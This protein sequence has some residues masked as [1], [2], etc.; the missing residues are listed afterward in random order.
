MQ[1]AFLSHKKNL[2]FDRITNI[3]TMKNYFILFIPFIVHTAVLAQSNMA[4]SFMVNDIKVI[5]KPTNKDI[6]HVS[7]YFRGGVGNYPAEKAGIEKLAVIGA[8]DCGNK[9]YSTNEFKDKSDLFGIELSASSHLDDSRISLNCISKY[10]DEGWDLF[11]QSILNPA[12]NEEA[13]EKVKQNSY[14]SMNQLQGNPDTRLKSL[15]VQNAFSGTPYATSPDGTDSS[16][17]GLSRN[18]VND[19]Y[20]KTLLNKTRIFIV[21]VGKISKEEIAARIAASFAGIPAFE[22]KISSFETPGFTKTTLDIE[23]RSIATNYILGIVN[24]P[25]YTS[26]DYTPYLLSF[27]ELSG[28][29]FAELRMNTGLSYA[30]GAHVYPLL[31]PYADVHVSTTSP[32]EAVTAIVK[33][34][35]TEENS[36]IA[37]KSLAQI[38]ALYITRNYMKDE[39]TDAI[40]ESLGNSEILGNW[41]IAE[42]FPS[43]LKNTTRSEMSAVFKKYITGIKWTYLGDKAKAD[44]SMSSFYNDFK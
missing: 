18:E 2:Q 3:Y 8:I 14:A 37:R 25:S 31:M 20:Y 16:L 43:L 30:P 19:Y 11:S 10:F 34:I 7:L 38:K 41:M 12:Y 42:Q 6:I 21:V 40:A 24:A 36:S 13:F 32:K 33:A 5:Y 35:Q 17:A 15:A 9:K 27:S 23:Q 22:Y 4:S 1:K 44:E 39:S 26:P 29:L 28:M